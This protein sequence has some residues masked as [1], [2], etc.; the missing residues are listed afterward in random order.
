MKT[1]P[2]SQTGLQKKTCP[3]KQSFI[4]RLQ[5]KKFSDK[6][7]EHIIKVRNKFETKTMKDYHD[8]YLK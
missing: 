8:L 5:V 6:D 3:T 4:G 1:Q 7:Y 2:F